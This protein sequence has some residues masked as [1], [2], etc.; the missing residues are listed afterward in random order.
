MMVHGEV[1]VEV[2][3]VIVPM[4]VSAPVDAL[5]LKAETLLD[6]KNFTT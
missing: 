3:T 5:M 2:P 4:L 6:A 1:N